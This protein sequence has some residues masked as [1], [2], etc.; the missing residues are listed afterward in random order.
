[1][2]LREEEGGGG[3]NNILDTVPQGGGDEG[4]PSGGFPR[5]VQ[6]ADGYEG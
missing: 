5:K 4:V 1:M 2:Q 6:D 3:A